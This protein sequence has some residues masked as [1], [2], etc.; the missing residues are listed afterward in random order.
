MKYLYKTDRDI[1]GL[2]AAS[3][4]DFCFIYRISDDGG[5]EEYV[6]DASSQEEA[7]RIV[8]ALN[9]LEQI[10]FDRA[11]KLL[12][13]HRGWKIDTTTTENDIGE[14]KEFIHPQT[15]EKMAWLDA[16]F[17]QNEIELEQEDI[18]QEFELVN[19]LEEEPHE[20]RFF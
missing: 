7:E 3:S 19:K 8:D 10:P 15:G 14:L 5:K 4:N 13:Q 16:I 20:I 11:L 18:T 6:A 1:T 17:A 12:L 9:L 2:D